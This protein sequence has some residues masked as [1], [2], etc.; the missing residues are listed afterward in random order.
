M[1][2][3]PKKMIFFSHRNCVLDPEN[4]VSSIYVLEIKISGMSL[5]GNIEWLTQNNYIVEI[6]LADDEISLFFILSLHFM[7]LRYIYYFHLHLILF[8]FVSVFPP[9]PALPIAFSLSLPSISLVFSAEKEKTTSLSRSPPPPYKRP[10]KQ[11]FSVFNKNIF[12]MRVKQMTITKAKAKSKTNV[13]TIF[14]QANA[15]AFGHITFP[16]IVLV[17]CRRKK[18]KQHTALEM[19]FLSIVYQTRAAYWMLK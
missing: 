11:R 10:N 13:T 3:N 2:L 17:N 15:N 16:R 4:C 14:A 1:W 7:I 12:A 18:K 19:L 9:G 8:F 5:S 6:A